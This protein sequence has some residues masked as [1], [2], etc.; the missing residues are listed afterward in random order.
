MNKQNKVRTAITNLFKRYWTVVV[1][2]VIAIVAL[3]TL[4]SLQSLALGLLHITCGL[5]CALIVRQV[6]HTTD[7]KYIDSDK[8][9]E[10]FLS[11][12]WKDLVRVAIVRFTF[13]IYFAI[14][15]YVLIK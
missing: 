1:V 14:C 6:I 4:P 15:V 12:S 9:T 13:L 11:S 7:D 10:D 2:V 5:A 8:Y 3:F